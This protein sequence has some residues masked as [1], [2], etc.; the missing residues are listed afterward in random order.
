M[1]SLAH[2]RAGQAFRIE[3]VLDQSPDFLRYLSEVGL[4]L[5][6]EGMVVSHSVEGGVITLAIDGLK[7]TLASGIAEKL[8]VTMRR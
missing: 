3:R 2:G 5:G 8:L 7:T 6:A 1:Q 4:P